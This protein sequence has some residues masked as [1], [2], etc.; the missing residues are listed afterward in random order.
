MPWPTPMHMVAAARAVPRRRSSCNR[1]VV[2]LAPEQPSGWPIAI[3][4]PL[5]FTRSGSSLSSSMTPTA[6]AAVL[7]AFDIAGTGPIPCSPDAR[8]PRRCRRTWPSALPRP[9]SS[10]A[11]AARAKRGLPGGQIRERQADPDSL[12]AG[13]RPGRRQG[14]HD[15]LGQQAR[16]RRG[17]GALMAGQGELVLALPVHV[18][19][20]GHVLR[21]LAESYRRVGLGHPR[22]DQ[23]PAQPRIA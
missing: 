14:R 17:S 4:P 23:A 15:L 3:A 16:G 1:V 12:I 2:I 18:V 21:G 19:A 10:R 11:P 6:W 5:T 8:L 9:R 7:S 13:D 20:L 22:A